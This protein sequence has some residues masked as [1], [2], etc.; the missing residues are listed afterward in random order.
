[1]MAPKNPPSAFAGADGVATANNVETASRMA[2][3]LKLS[4]I[5]RTA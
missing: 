2:L 3:A 5:C 1:M 4:G